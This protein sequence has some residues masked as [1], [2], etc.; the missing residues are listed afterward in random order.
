MA[1]ALKEEPAASAERRFEIETS[2]NR[3][4]RT[5]TAYYDVTFSPVKS[6]SM[7]YTALLAAGDGEGAET[8]R[9]AHDEAVRIA[10]SS[11]QSDVAYVRSGRD[12]GRGPSGRTVGQ[13]EA[14]TG[15][16]AVVYG[17]HTSRDGGPQLHS[18][19]GVLNRAATADGRVLALD[20]Q[21]FRPVKEALSAASTR[22][23]QQL[24][25]EEMGVLFQQRPDGLAREIAG[26]DPELLAQAS[27]RTL[28]RVR[29][30]VAEL[31]EAYTA[32]HGRAPGPRARRALVEQAVKG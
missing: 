18:H 10:L 14:A 28:E 12:E 30:A 9:W 25:T 4:T 29:P 24:L 22:A 1:D 27:T 2:A 11:V 21:A 7:Y 17:H 31:V 8:V 6:V 19:A 20:G 3:N 15:L 23:Y 13:W 16:A 26:F 32:R 5:P